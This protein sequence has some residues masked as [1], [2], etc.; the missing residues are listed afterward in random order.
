MVWGA[1]GR[2]DVTESYRRGARIPWTSG[3]DEAVKPDVTDAVI[4]RLFLI[5][6]DRPSKNPQSRIDPPGEWGRWCFSGRLCDL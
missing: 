2:I 4:G 1:A 3:H 5:P 6:M